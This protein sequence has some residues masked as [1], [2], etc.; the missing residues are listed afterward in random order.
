MEIDNVWFLNQ[1][2]RI[3]ASLFGKSYLKRQKQYIKE[4]RS[5]IN[6]IAI[7]Y[8]VPKSNTEKYNNWQDGFTEAVKL[9]SD[10]YDVTWIN[11]E[12][13]KPTSKELNSYD[14]IIAKS[15]WNWIVDKY[16]RSLKGLT[17]ARGICISCSLPPRNILWAYFYDI[18]WY[19]TF[20]YEK[21]INFHPNI[22]HGFGVN[23]NAFKPLDEEKIYDV[24]SIGTLDKFKR[25]EKIID[26]S[27][28][29]KMVIGAKSRNS[30]EIEKKLRE[31]NVEIKEYATQYEL[32]RYINQSQLVYI[33]CEL[34]GGGERAVLEARA[35]GV[36]VRIE[37]DNAKLAELTQGFV[38]DPQ[39]YYMQL[40][41]G[42]E[43]VFKRNVYASCLIE[44]SSK[45]ISGMFSFY[46][47]NLQISGDENVFIGSYCSF[48][49][50]VS[51]ITSNH[52]TNYI[53]TQGY[54]YRRYFGTNHPGEENII[55]NKERTKGPV[56]IGN[57]V[58]IGDNV[59]I[60]SGVTIG[61]GACI[62][63]GSVVCNDIG[64]YEISG[65]VP[66]KIIKRRFD[67]ETTNKLLDLKWWDWTNEEMI[68]N[69]E[70]FYTNFNNLNKMV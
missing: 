9:L 33:P 61:D 57:D 47:T 68:R 11:L 53:S 50:N 28:S 35:C 19:E 54:L 65:G 7:I 8:Y 59:I 25:L 29:K 66:N 23:T 3:Y 12:D 56:R 40:R 21:H 48:G 34:Q 39:Y 31:N 58:W 46:N 27:G 1:K 10:Y 64:D 36:P 18:L 45:V 52:D 2:K 24:I 6:K 38:W 42:V 5:S 13:K 14:F 51:I 16:V 43:S 60:L 37:K 55:P 69:K 41:K 20:S 70:L 26:I 17:V 67:E 15:C 49:K 22:I 62:A 4:N 44:S 32:S 30:A 63:A